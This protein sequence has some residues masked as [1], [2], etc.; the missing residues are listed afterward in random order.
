MSIRRILGLAFL[1][2]LAIMARPHAAQSQ[3]VAH[4]K[5][6]HTPVDL[7][8]QGRILQESSQPLP[9]QLKSPPG[10]IDLSSL[11]TYRV[12]IVR[13]VHGGERNKQIT[14]VN[15]AD[16]ALRMD[17]DFIFYLARNSDGTYNISKLDNL[18]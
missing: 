12:R 2:T 14:V 16:P 8:I 15:I 6:N 5:K 18:R 3:D 17:K 7:V 10:W 9:E 13:V 1:A 11:W 4:A